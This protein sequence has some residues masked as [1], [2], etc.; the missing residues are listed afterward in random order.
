M[1][2]NLCDSCRNTKLCSR[3]S[4]RILQIAYCFSFYDKVDKRRY[5]SNFMCLASARY[6]RNV[7]LSDKKRYSQVSDIFEDKLV[8]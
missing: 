3:M 6:Y 8:I 1:S 5:K 4:K 2:V 7:I